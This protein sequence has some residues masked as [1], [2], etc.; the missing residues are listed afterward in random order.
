[1]QNGVG[2]LLVFL[3]KSRFIRNS[4]NSNKSFDE[5][6]FAGLPR[7]AIAFSAGIK[8]AQF[9]DFRHYIVGTEKN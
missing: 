8:R 3:R 6:T 4:S 7:V 5:S 9:L 1:M 2:S